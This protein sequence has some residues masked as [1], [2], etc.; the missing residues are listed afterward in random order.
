MLESPERLPRVPEPPP[1]PASGEGLLSRAVGGRGAVI[2]QRIGWL[3]ASAEERRL[4]LVE[5]AVILGG[6]L[7]LGVVMFL[8]L[9]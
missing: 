3:R 1:G 7:L 6:V 9:R 8:I 4:W 5:G 2:F